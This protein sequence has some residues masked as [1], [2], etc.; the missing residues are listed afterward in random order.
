MYYDKQGRNIDM[1]EAAKL[2]KDMDYKRI[3]ETTLLDGKWVST[4]WLGLNHAFGDT[5]LPLI[6][7]TM[8]F[9]SRE[10]FNDLDCERYTF[11]EDAVG[12]HEEMVKKWES[13]MG[14]KETQE[15]GE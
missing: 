11:L 12:G 4:V 5:R 8:V 10:N 3:A 6:F 14:E 2:L 13:K 9:P 15:V 1:N 7:E